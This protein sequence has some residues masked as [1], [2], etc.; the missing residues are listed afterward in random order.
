MRGVSPVPNAPCGVESTYSS[1]VLQ[2]PGRSVP[3]APCGV[4]S[5]ENVDKVGKRVFEFL[6]HR[7][8][9]KARRTTTLTPFISVFLMHR[10]ELKVAYGDG[11]I[12]ND[13][14]FLMHR[15]ELKGCLHRIC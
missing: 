1:G 14:G 9:L 13:S 3:N 10:V 11:N 12:R 8:E 6:M 7:V 15:V 4:E 5:I 2:G